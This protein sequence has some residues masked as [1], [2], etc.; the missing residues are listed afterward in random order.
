MK[1]SILVPVFNVERYLNDCLNSIKSQTFKDFEV[2]LIDDGSTDS[3]GSICDEFKKSSCCNTKVVHKKN[4]GLIAARRNAIKLAKGE[5]LIF[6]DSDDYLEV[7]A[8][9][10]LNNILSKNNNIDMVIYNAYNVFNSKKKV[11]FNHVFN[12]GLVRKET[13][14]NELLLSYRINAIWLKAVKNCIVDKEKDYS[15][16]YDCNFGEDLLQTIP[17]IDSSTNIYY[18]DQELYNYRTFSG[19]MHK[20]NSNYYWS[21]KKINSA[22]RNYEFIKLLLNSTVKLDF[23]LL[24]AAYGATTQTKY[25][26]EFN[27]IKFEEI[28]KDK[29][30]RA[31]YKNVKKYKYFY[32]KLGIKKKMILSMLFNKYYKCIWILLHIRGN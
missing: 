10:V 11:F 17:L 9:E 13:I 22:I 21:Y 32:D 3:S 8:L 31:A 6:C 2:I 16:F 4:E 30:F 14:Y 29:N 27:K 28:A 24:C 7:N 5:F 1:F 23:H 19:M 15:D 18:L 20:Y 25:L 12:E 26:K